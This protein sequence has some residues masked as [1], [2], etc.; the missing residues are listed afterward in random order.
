MDARLT[1]PVT[2]EQADWLQRE[3]ARGDPPVTFIVW[4]CIELAAREH[5]RARTRS[6]ACG[7]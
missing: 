7:Q 5:G 2:R 1:I 3:A 6:R 4:R